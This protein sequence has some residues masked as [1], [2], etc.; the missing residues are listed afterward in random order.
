MEKKSYIATLAVI[1]LAYAMGWVTGCSNRR[2]ES[3]LTDTTHTVVYDTL[4]YYDVVPRDSVVIRYETH[5]LAL[6]HSV[7]TLANSCNIGKNWQDSTIAV[8]SCESS[9]DMSSDSASVIIPITQ[10]V[11]EDSLYTAYVSGYLPSLDSLLLRLPTHTYT[12]NTRT[13]VKS[14]RWGIGP[15]IGVG[16]NGKEIRPYIGVGITYNLI[17]F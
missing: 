2:S 5:T 16:W 17:S 8:A 4:K 7:P 3:V 11:Y 15:H 6:A 1:I 14:K 12:I 10:K 13:P 9:Q